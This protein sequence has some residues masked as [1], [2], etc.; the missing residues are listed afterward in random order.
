MAPIIHWFRRDLRL[1]DNT[2]LAA[3]ARDS[4]GAVLPVFILDDA[5]LCGR[6]ASPPRAAFLLASLGSLDADLRALGSRLLV[7]RGEPLRELLSLAR[8]SQAQG[9]YW[10][11]DYTPYAVRRDGA[12]EAGL[13]SAGLRAQS[14]KDAVAFEMLEVATQQ[15]RPYAIY[16]PYARRWRQLLAERGLMLAPAPSL[17]PLERWP[18]SLPIPALEDLGLALGATALPPAGEAAAI[19][20]LRA[21]ADPRREP[22]MAG[23]APARDLPGVDG[24]SRLSPHLRLGSLSPRQ[25]LAT[26]LSLREAEAARAGADAWVGELIWRDFYAQVLFH[27]PHALRGAFRRELDA[28]AWEN[29]EGLFRAW[30]EGRTGYPLVDAAMRQL[31]QEGWMHNRARMVVA[32]FL[33]KDLLVDWRWGERHFMRLLV[34]GDP[35]ANN[36]G[37][38]WAAGTGTDAQPY[39]RIFNPASQGQRF[40]PQGA[41][42][43][44][45]LPELANVPD[46]HIH[47]PHLM[48]LAEQLRA[49]VQVGRDY[50]APIVDHGAQRVRALALYR[51][52]RG[53]PSNL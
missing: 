53:R 31:R 50:P 33:T 52:A 7:R 11:R 25:C 35:A 47:A 3:A 39:F 45:Y 17:A 26:A 30:Q 8:E 13:R 19:S 4:G 15:G 41:Y 32:S 6:H 20:R 34:D 42:V 16:T 12:A 38:Q 51:V 5:L 43:R 49:D 37:W 9:V 29:D 27:H 28:L 14:F 1:A 40:D 36:G 23:Y 22:G 48:A 10:N 21:F 18:A 24:T 46:R 44:R 2:A